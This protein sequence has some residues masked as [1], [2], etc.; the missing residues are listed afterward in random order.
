M[1]LEEEGSLFNAQFKIRQRSE[2][3]DNDED[4]FQFRFGE[5]LFGKSLA[6]QVRAYEIT[7]PGAM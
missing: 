2:R 3:E 7:H 5:E 4:N 1:L 6:E